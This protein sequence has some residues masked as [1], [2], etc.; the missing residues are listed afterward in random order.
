MVERGKVGEMP[1][2][3]PDEKQLSG[4]TWGANGDGARRLGRDTEDIW[5]VLLEGW[6]SAE[7]DDLRAGSRASRVRAHHGFARITG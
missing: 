5:F 4:Q 6:W 3:M 7:R 2:G 1:D